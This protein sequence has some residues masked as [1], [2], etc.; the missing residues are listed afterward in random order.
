MEL[1][2]FRF[3]GMVKYYCL[4]NI[5]YL[6]KHLLSL[7]QRLIRLEKIIQLFFLAVAVL[8]VVVVVAV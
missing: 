4:L 5:L 2:W 8:E 1:R 3:I 7:V 6:Q